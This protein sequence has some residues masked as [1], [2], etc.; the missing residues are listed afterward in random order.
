[1]YFTDKIDKLGDVNKKEN[2]RHYS[3]NCFFQNVLVDAD[4]MFWA[5]LADF[6]R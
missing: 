3:A 5:S 2:W 6:G 4:K 1:M